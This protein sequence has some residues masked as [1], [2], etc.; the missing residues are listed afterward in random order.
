MFDISTF[1]PDETC[2]SKFGQH[3]T[4]I[5]S[6]GDVQKRIGVIVTRNL[7]SFEGNQP[8]VQTYLG[9]NELECVYEDGMVDQAEYVEYVGAS[10]RFSSKYN[11]RHN[12]QKKIST[13]RFKE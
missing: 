3:G 4:M 2:T 10:S 9:Q 5:M 7:S 11:A 13:Y 6:L 12:T 1:Q 8:F